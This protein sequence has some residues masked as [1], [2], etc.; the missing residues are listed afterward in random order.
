MEERKRRH[1]GKADIVP[2]AK[3]KLLIR[4]LNKEYKE[5]GIPLYPE[6]D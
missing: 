5:M 4:E 6:V 2:D 3:Q 1:T